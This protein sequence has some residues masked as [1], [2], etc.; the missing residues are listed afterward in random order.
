MF[1]DPSHEPELIA[2]A[3][4]GDLIAFNELV[5]AYQNIAYTHARNLLGDPDWA[6]DA[7]Q[8]SFIKIFQK[9]NAFRGGSFRAWMLK[10]VTNTS[11]DL[12]RKAVR[13]PEHPLHPMND[14][15]DEFETPY[16]LT[17]SS[18]SVEETIQQREEHACLYQLLDELPVDFRSAITLV[19]IHELDYAE[20]GKALGIPLGT[21]KS[22]LARARLQMREKL[23]GASQKTYAEGGR[24]LLSNQN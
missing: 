4:R 16:W 9:I 10:V 23:K 13:H 1:A 8:E 19:D 3:S 22:R 2:S 15:G 12:Y 20:A 7:T 21:V 18:A 6:E 17:D 11:F 14:N 24:S 5:L